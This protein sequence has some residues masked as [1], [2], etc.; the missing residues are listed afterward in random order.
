M[1]VAAAC[2]A[3]ALLL[4]WMPAFADEREPEAARLEVLH[5]E[6]PLKLTGLFRFNPI[7]E[8]SSRPS[9]LSIEDVG[10][11]TV[12]DLATP[13][14]RVPGSIGLWVDSTSVEAVLSEGRRRSVVAFSDLSL[15][16]VVTPDGELRHRVENVDVARV[17]DTGFRQSGSGS[18]QASRRVWAI[19]YDPTLSVVELALSGLPDAAPGSLVAEYAGLDEER[20]GYGTVRFHTPGGHGVYAVQHADGSL[21][22][23]AAGKRN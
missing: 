3:I 21:S 22:F 7:Y 18:G 2:V 10:E 16:A 15:V 23:H 14:D 4:A 5:F 1:K 6:E 9:E 17:A 11:H 12:H 20:S 19:A 8:K 13:G